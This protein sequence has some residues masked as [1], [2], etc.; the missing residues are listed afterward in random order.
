MEIKRRINVRLSQLNAPIPIAMKIPWE[1]ETK[2]RTNEKLSKKN[3]SE[4]NLC[5][6]LEFFAVSKNIFKTYN[7]KHQRNE[8]YL[9]GFS[10]FHLLRFDSRHACVYTCERVSSDWKCSKWWPNC[11]KHLSFVFFLT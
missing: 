9:K 10:F 7:K 6:C 3:K 8:K 1:E 2:E 5:N 4:K 11:Q